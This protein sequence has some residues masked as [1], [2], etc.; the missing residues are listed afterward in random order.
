M[1]ELLTYSVE[2]KAWPRPAL[3]SSKG[4]ASVRYDT[5][6]GIADRYQQYK[7]RIRGAATAALPAGW[8]PIEGP[9][10]ARIVIERESLKTDP[11]RVWKVTTP[12]TENLIKPIVDA[13]TGLVFVD[14]RQVVILSVAE[15]YGPVDLITI[16]FN[17]LDDSD[18]DALPEPRFWFDSRPF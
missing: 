4:S 7:A 17:L 9:V 8:E 6:N 13:H 10:E 16:Q 11:D 2:E 14:D 1:R 5:R 15:T 12:D 3:V 18:T